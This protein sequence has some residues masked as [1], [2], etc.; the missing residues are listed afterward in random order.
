MPESPQPPGS[1]YKPQRTKTGTFAKGWSGNPGGD[2]GRARRVLNTST[3]REL[4]RAFDRGG[5]RAIEKVMKQQP[6]LFLKM[7]VLLV[8]REM[9]VTHSNAIK[10]M[11]DEQ[12]EAAIEVIQSMLADRERKT[13]DVQAVADN[14]VPALPASKR[15]RKPALDVVAKAGLEG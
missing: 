10:S 12:I 14:S 7:L 15:R 9:E 4:Q 8:P 6:A 5:R 11:S 1:P 2:G 3:I 13:I